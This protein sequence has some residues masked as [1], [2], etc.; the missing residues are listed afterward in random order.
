MAVED[1]RIQAA[2]LYKHFQSEEENSEEA[3]R[4]VEELRFHLKLRAGAEG[5]FVKKLVMG[6][7]HKRGVACKTWRWRGVPGW[8]YNPGTMEAPENG[9]TGTCMILH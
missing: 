4:E 1:K 6:R 9:E 3:E 8:C 5:Y 7:H 2:T